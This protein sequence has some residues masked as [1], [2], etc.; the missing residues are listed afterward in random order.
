METQMKIIRFIGIGCVVLTTGCSMLRGTTEVECWSD[1]N[2]KNHIVAKG[3]A[4]K[5]TVKKEDGT[6]YTIDTKRTSIVE[7]MLQLI[8][9][10]GINDT[11]ED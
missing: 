9:L 3:T 6:E 10:E 4:L 1:E 5:A 2:G 7:S 8:M 11:F